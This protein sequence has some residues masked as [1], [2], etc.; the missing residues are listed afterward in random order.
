MELD[1]CVCLPS[2]AHD[3]LN[4]FL[5]NPMGFPF[6]HFAFVVVDTRFHTCV[7]IADIDA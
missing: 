6:C 7:A 2:F 5:F 3:H 4:H 1:H